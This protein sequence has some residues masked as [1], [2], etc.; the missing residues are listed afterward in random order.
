MLNVVAV[1]Q[2]ART[3]TAS[4]KREEAV[5]FHAMVSPSSEWKCNTS[6]NMRGGRLR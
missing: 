1:Q 4:V 5:G 2:T 3:V 6:L